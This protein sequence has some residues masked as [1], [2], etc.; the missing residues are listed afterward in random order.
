MQAA[1]ARFWPLTSSSRLHIRPE[2]P[3]GPV[4]AEAAA[5]GYPVPRFA[6]Q[7]PELHALATRTT[8]SGNYS[9]IIRYNS[10][11]ELA[12]RPPIVEKEQKRGTI[13]CTIKG[14]SGGAEQSC[15]NTLTA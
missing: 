9:P 4:S 7:H 14:A 10:M 1:K 2:S 8:T 5:I 15:D 6:L 13:S 3:A 11:I 12:S